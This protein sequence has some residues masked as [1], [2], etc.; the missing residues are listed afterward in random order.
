MESQ[1]EIFSMLYLPR[2]SWIVSVMSKEKLLISS[3]EVFYKAEYRNRFELIGANGKIIH[4]SG[5][6]RIDAIDHFGIFNDEKKAYTHHLRVI[7]RMI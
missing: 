5:K 4:A 6:V 3:N 7:K 2:I 1:S